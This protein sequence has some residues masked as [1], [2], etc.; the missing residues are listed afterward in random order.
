[1]RSSTVLIVLGVILGVGGLLA[2]ANPFAASLAVTTLVGMLLILSG[3]LQLWVGVTDK[4][5]AHRIWTALIGLVGLIAGVSLIANPLAG[6]ISLTLLVG[7]VFLITG[8]ARLGMAWR[9]RETRL[10]WFLLLSGAASLLIGFMVVGNIAAAATTLLG[11]LLGIQLLA[12][13]LG[14]LALGLTARKR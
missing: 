14:L 1:M 12:D 2:I 3:A 7:I 11:L 13:G 6:V 5:A 10:F 8:G 9:L 4:D